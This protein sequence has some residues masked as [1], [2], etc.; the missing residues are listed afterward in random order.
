MSDW[1]NFLK[2]L[3]EL[4]E[5]DKQDLNEIFAPT[6]PLHKTI[7]V[8]GLPCSGKTLFIQNSSQYRAEK[9][10]SINS[11]MTNWFA[12]EDDQTIMYYEAPFN[13]SLPEMI[14]L[15]L[16]Y[17]NEHY[18]LER[19]PNENAAMVYQCSEVGLLANRTFY[20]KFVFDF[21]RHD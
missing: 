13:Q 6:K 17:I 4:T 9:I 5:Q 8:T 10:P 16:A 11:F 19:I 15:Q 3:S 21:T 18:H 7:L 14:R 12:K 1:Q 20:N 2:Q